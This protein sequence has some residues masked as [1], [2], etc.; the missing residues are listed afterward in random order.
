MNYIPDQKGKVLEETL[1]GFYS[2]VVKTTL[3]G[4]RYF[5]MT[6]S[7]S[8]FLQKSLPMSLCHIQWRVL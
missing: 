8:Q 2:D 5:K 6:L 1:E 7:F 3:I 4:L